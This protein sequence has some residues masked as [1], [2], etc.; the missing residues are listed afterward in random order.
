M[1]QLPPKYIM[2]CKSD[3]FYIY[4]QAF[5][6]GGGIITQQVGYYPTFLAA[7]QAMS[8]VCVGQEFIL[9]HSSQIIDNEFKV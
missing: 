3:M 7:L 4:E 5:L 6:N 9:A 2:T 8:D 1:N